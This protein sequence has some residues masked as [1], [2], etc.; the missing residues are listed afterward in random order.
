MCIYILFYLFLSKNSVLHILLWISHSWSFSISK[1]WKSVKTAEA[2]L[3]WEWLSYMSCQCPGVRQSL[4]LPPDEIWWDKGRRNSGP[5]P[6]TAVASCLV[7]VGWHLVGRWALLLTSHSPCKMDPIR[8]VGLRLL[9]WS[10][11]FFHGSGNSGQ[12]VSFW[13]DLC[14]FEGCHY[15][16]VIT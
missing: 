14:V 16:S 15:L 11:G 4:F 6:Y 1:S 9:R 2:E 12:W 13:K 10:R 5:H 8:F 7:C 3:T